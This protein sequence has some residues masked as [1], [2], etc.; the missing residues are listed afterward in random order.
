MNTKWYYLFLR[1]QNPIIIPL[2]LCIAGF[3][4]RFSFFR[5]ARWFSIVSLM[6]VCFDGLCFA[7]RRTA[8]D[9][10]T[11]TVTELHDTGGGGGIGI[12]GGG[13]TIG[14]YTN[15]SCDEQTSNSVCSDPT[16]STNKDTVDSSH[17]IHK[18]TPSSTARNKLLSL[19]TLSNFDRKLFFLRT[20]KMDTHDTQTP[21]RGVQQQ[22][23]QP[24]NNQFSLDI[25]NRNHSNRVVSMCFLYHALN[26]SFIARKDK[27]AVY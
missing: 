26:H 6:R 10:E 11:Q 15:H 25:A 8:V 21:L 24:L 9:E 19:L 13:G 3:A 1:E 5:W 4:I 27:T 18:H 16:A 23:Q 20:T 12:A 22:Q 14:C 7:S 2:F 17:K